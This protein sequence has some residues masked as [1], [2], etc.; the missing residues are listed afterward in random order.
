MEGLCDHILSEIFLLCPHDLRQFRLVS[1]KW[2]FV[3]HNHKILSAL[4]NNHIDLL[5][6]ESLI[7]HDLTTL[8]YL[9][10]HQ[11]SDLWTQ[12]TDQH[13]DSLLQCALMNHDLAMIQYLSD[14][15]QLLTH[16]L[17]IYETSGHV[18][19]CLYR[20]N[21]PN[22]VDH[23]VTCDGQFNY[24]IHITTLVKSNITIIC[25]DDSHKLNILMSIK[26]TLSSYYNPSGY[27]LNKPPSDIS[28]FHISDCRYIY[29]NYLTIEF[30]TI[31]DHIQFET[32]QDDHRGYC[33]SIAR[34][35]V[36]TYI[37]DPIKSHNDKREYVYAYYKIDNNHLTQSE[38]DTVHLW[39][40]PK[41]DHFKDRLQPMLVKLI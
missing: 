27:H 4:V 31:C 21:R 29:T 9:Y 38:I 22:R 3:I 24:H 33:R 6:Q 8:Y 1:K 23:F 19:S 13:Y 41:L 7:N 36:Y 34:D 35:N 2:C 15:N 28:L 17:Q 26:N 11:I 14:I 16:H 32:Y 39:T 20:N 10:Q 5:C 12:I 25:S 18:T 40:K 30:I 37:L